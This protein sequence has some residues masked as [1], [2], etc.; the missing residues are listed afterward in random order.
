[1]TMRPLTPSPPGEPSSD[2]VAPGWSGSIL[3][4]SYAPHLR[5]MTA[6]PFAVASDLLH[7]SRRAP[8]LAT[9][10]AVHQSPS[11]APR[12]GA[13][14]G[15]RPPDSPDRLVG[16]SCRRRK[17]RSGCRGGRPCGSAHDPH[18][19]HRHLCPSSWSP[20]PAGVGR[21]S[22]TS[23]AY[24]D[25]SG[26]A[27]WPTPGSRPVGRPPP[28]GASSASAS[29]EHSPVSPPRRPGSPDDPVKDRAAAESLAAARRR[30]GVLGEQVAELR[31]RPA[32]RSC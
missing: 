30:L 1:M 23:E 20:P 18:L 7:V 5:S 26:S 13:R 25:R 29:A 9:S 21:S 15:P 22:A 12:P 31:P 24:A 3:I 28:A 32:A 10:P 27:S 6:S 11:R 16:S 17:G 19:P 2:P 8:G 4:D 14:E